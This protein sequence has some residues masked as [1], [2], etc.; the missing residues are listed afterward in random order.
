MRRSG[1]GT[2][3][4]HT[5]RNDHAAPDFSLRYSEVGGTRVSRVFPL[6]LVVRELGN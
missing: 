6:Y 2:Q 4:A 3:T 1:I 5:G